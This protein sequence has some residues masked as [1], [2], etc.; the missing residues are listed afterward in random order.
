MSLGVDFINFFALYVL[1]Q[2]IDIAL[3]ICA[4]AQL[5]GH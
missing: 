3:Y 1:A 5:L 4:Y 2:I